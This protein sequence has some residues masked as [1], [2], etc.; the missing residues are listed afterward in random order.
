MFWVIIGIVI[1]LCVLLTGVILLQNPKGGLASGVAATQ[2]MGVKRTTDV[3]ERLTWGF[4][5]AIIVLAI[6]SAFIVPKAAQGEIPGQVNIRKGREK[7]VPAPQPVAPAPAPQN[8]A[9][10]TVDTVAH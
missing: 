6:S 9:P 2:L 8:T 4:M 3:L 5:I 1:L 10:A 7:A